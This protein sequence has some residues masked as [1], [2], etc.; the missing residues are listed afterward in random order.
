M[1]LRFGLAKKDDIGEMF[2]MSTLT[3]EDYNYTVV[4][5]SGIKNAELGVL[6]IEKN[7]IEL[8]GFDE[9]FLNTVL[10]LPESQVTYSAFNFAYTNGMYWFFDKETRVWTSY[11]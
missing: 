9:G 8:Y 4:I 5:Y 1:N 7:Q 3:P 6:N 2:E 10:K 11:K